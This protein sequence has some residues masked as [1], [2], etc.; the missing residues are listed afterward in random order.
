MRNY[1]VEVPAWGGRRDVQCFETEFFARSTAEEI[2]ALAPGLVVL[3]WSFA[4]TSY[5]ARFKGGVA[6]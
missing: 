2:S 1:R 4:S 3:V 5:I 6:G